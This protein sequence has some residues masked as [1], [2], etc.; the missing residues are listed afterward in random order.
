[1][2]ILN[3]FKNRP[4]QFD[5]D[6]LS[7]ELILRAIDKAVSLTNPRLKLVGSYQ[8]CLTPAVE[9]C[10]HYL[11][12][13]IRTLPSTITVASSCWISDPSLRAFFVTAS[14]IPLA[15]S[16][17]SNLRTLFDKYPALEEAHFILEMGYSEQNVYGVS[18]VGEVVQRDVAQKVLSFSDHQARICGHSDVEI[19]RLLGTQS[20]EYLVAQALSEIGDERS[21][22]RELEDNRALIRARLRLFQQQGPGLGSVFRSAPDTSGEQLKLEAQLQEN[23]RQMEA[24]GSPRSALDKELECLCDVLGHPERYLCMK[25]KKPCLNTMNV[26]LDEPQ[27]KASS[28][29]AFSLAELMGIPKLQRA[30]VLARLARDEFLPVKSSFEDAER[31]L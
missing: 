18:L 2:D 15:L 9:N 20:F 21:E 27:D 24:I 5:P 25:Q 14:D 16:H 19:R 23:E 4:S 11:R 31:Y 30:F 29:V 7:E 3:W 1:M 12:A 28:E 8:E 17:S 13:M 10:I 26:V 22:R 6:R